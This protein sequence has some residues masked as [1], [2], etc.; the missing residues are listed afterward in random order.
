MKSNWRKA[1]LA[2]VVERFIDYRG[3]TPKKTNCGVPLI[4]A[5]IVKNGR[6][7]PIQEY[8]DVASYDTWMTRGIP[9]KGAI[10][11]TTEAPMGEVAQLKISEKVAFAQRVIVIEGKE[12]V[13][14]NTFLLY[15]LQSPIIQHRL[16][17]RETG[18]TVT[19]IKSKE[20]KKIIIDFP[21]FDIQKKIAEIL[22]NFDSKIELNNQVISNLEELASTLFKRW[23]VEFEFPDENGNP[24][25]S[26]GGKMVDSELGEIPEGWEITNLGTLYKCKSGYAFKSKD[27]FITGKSVVKIKNINPP[28][29][30][31]DN[32]SFFHNE[33]VELKAKDFRVHGGEILMAL[34]GGTVTKFG[35]VPDKTDAYVNQRVGM[36]LDIQGFGYGILYGL[37]NQNDVIGHFLNNSEGSAQPNLSP[38]IINSFKLAFNHDVLYKMSIILNSLIM[39]V[40]NLLC[41]NIYL[42]TLRD[43]LLPKLLSGEIELPED[44]EV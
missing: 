7:Q 28:S 37:L 36:F 16:R 44:E 30:R 25:K 21:E 31:V 39:N 42:E 5:K 14:D 20:L 32:E 22:V 29:V 40:S 38:K 33:E 18:T 23:F 19:G 4:T 13:L 3:K 9:Q 6:I 11:L 2:E 8:I 41:E 10:I 34:T 43:T 35:V 15:A 17:E 27:W 26:S 1:S 12:G 24:Y